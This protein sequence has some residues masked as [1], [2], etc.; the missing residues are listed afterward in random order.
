MFLSALSSFD[1]LSADYHPYGDNCCTLVSGQKHSPIA[2]SRAGLFSAKFSLIQFS[3][4]QYLWLE[5]EYEISLSKMRL[6]NVQMTI[7]KSFSRKHLFVF[8]TRRSIQLKILR[9]VS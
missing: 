8:I 6:M 3:E 4:P 2:V 7:L 9:L 1:P 5:V